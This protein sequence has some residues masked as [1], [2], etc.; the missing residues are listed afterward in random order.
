MVKV[1]G[2][3]ARGK[4]GR[5][6]GAREPQYLK[7]QREQEQE[8]QRQ[9]Q[10]KKEEQY[11]EEL[12]EY[13]L[14]KQRYEKAL[15]KYNQAKREEQEWE[16]ARNWIRRGK[17]TYAA[18]SNPSL[19][20]K[21]KILQERGLTSWENVA[22]AREQYNQ[23]IADLES[24]GFIPVYSNG[25]LTGFED[26]EAQMS[27][28]IEEF[29][30]GYTRKLTPFQEYV[31][32]YE[33]SLPTKDESEVWSVSPG[34]SKLGQ[35]FQSIGAKK[36]DYNVTRG[37]Y[38]W[39]LSF[40]DFKP[41]GGTSEFLFENIGSVG[42][43]IARGPKKQ[44]TIDGQT[45]TFYPQSYQV[46]PTGDLFKLSGQVGLLVSPAGPYYLTAMGTEHFLLPA[47]RKEIKDIG[48]YWEKEY[49]V[50]SQASWL[51]PTA[52]LGLGTSK[53]WY[54]RAKGWWNTRGRTKEITFSSEQWKQIESGERTFPTK[55]GSK[56]W[57]TRSRLQYKEFMKPGDL[58]LKYD[59]GTGGIH[60]SSQVPELELG[61]TRPLHLAPQ[62]GPSA[63]FL[64][65]GSS[66]SSQVLKGNWLDKFIEKNFADVINP[67][68]SKPGGAFIQPEGGFEIKW[69]LE[70][71][72]GVYNWGGT[73]PKP[74]T[75]YVV[76]TKAET[77]AVL[78]EGPTVKTSSDY[79]FK[80]RGVRYPLD[81]YEALGTSTSFNKILTPSQDISSVSQ[82][83]SSYIN[84]SSYTYP[85]FSKIGVLLPSSSSS[86]SSKTSS[87]L[88]IPFSKIPS[89]L[90]VSKPKSSKSFPSISKSSY[91][92]FPKP[93][94]S[95]LKSS[96]T[97]KKSSYFY[98]FKTRKPKP[99]PRGPPPLMFK[100]PSFKLPSVIKY[101]KKSRI[102][103]PIRM[104]SLASLGL[105]I[106]SK[107]K[108]KAEFS[109][110]SIRPILIKPSGIFKKKKKR[111]KK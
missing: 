39:T 5:Q 91:F 73:S 80:F 27:I 21:I 13:T 18:K 88:S 101:E 111:R 77:Q 94:R 74:G 63:H 67:S 40:K 41:V 83:T 75:A 44:T 81:T 53:W 23:Q 48:S 79:F 105:G 7:E 106:K 49:G 76:G 28:P 109:G 56:D 87:K 8:E 33:S 64:G 45:Y 35:Y 93:L 47:G 10:L 57:L 95:S 9:E 71:Q 98:G 102:K 82:V 84:P 11:Q 4:L 108:G 86:F 97:T 15:E 16:T 54:P 69:G 55:G 14:E 107:R 70:T 3:V 24:Q 90:K 68:S 89:S 30:K 99:K 20:R 1:G 65:V 66:S 22:E 31:K 51:I 29:E 2:V 34:V 104:P 62:T 72:R 17:P 96:K 25:K 60:M 100:L 92:S 26:T 19:Y 50:P 38:D 58:Q 12:E 110:L 6:V 37:N 42:R 85:S 78:V 52:E 61:I 46:K 59:F 103:S 43:K 36:G 32:G